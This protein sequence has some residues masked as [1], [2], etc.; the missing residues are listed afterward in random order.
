MLV[1]QRVKTQTTILSGCWSGWSPRV[2]A[3]LA[4]WHAVWRRWRPG[5][6]LQ[7][8]WRPETERRGQGRMGVGAGEELLDVKKYNVYMYII[9]YDIYITQYINIRCIDNIDSIDNFIHPSIGP[10]V[11]LF[12]Y[13]SIC[14][15]I[16]LCIYIYRYTD[17]W[18]FMYFGS[19]STED[20][21]ECASIL[22]TPDFWWMML[23]SYGQTI[24]TEIEFFLFPLKARVFMR[25]PKT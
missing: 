17:F 21:W 8:S 7:S 23:V 15:S 6:R 3:T 18:W 24:T 10:S 2:T 22:S 5:W 4:P 19:V 16:C 1:Y 25:L 9:Y 20:D 12:L 14:A 13:L 11:H